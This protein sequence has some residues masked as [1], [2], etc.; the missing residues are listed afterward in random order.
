MDG[1]ASGLFP[2][3][4]EDIM[5]GNE[6]RRTARIQVDASLRVYIR[7]IGNNVKYEF[8][9]QN[10][11]NQ[12]LKLESRKTRKY[13]FSGSTLLDVSMQLDTIDKPILQ[14]VCK[15][16]RVYEDEGNVQFGVRIV[17]I[18]SEDMTLLNSYIEQ[19]IEEGETSD[20]LSKVS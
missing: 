11:S 9:T 3:L 13:P 2:Y 18:D 17:Q 12:G 4:C 10:I 14:F 19:C 5:A 1:I 8:W 7:S 15:V 6:K 16:A 20:N